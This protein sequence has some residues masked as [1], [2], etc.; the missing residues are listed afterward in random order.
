MRRMKS[1]LA[2]P[3][4]GAA[5]YSESEDV[6]WYFAAEVMDYAGVMRGTEEYMKEQCDT[7]IEQIEEREKED[8][9]LYGDEF[10]W[11]KK[12][13]SMIREA[14]E[15]IRGI[16]N[17]PSITTE[18]VEKK[19]TRAPITF[20]E[21]TQDVPEMYMIKH[22]ASSGQSFPGITSVSQ[23]Q[24]PPASDGDSRDTLSDM[25]DGRMVTN[26]SVNEASGGTSNPNIRNRVIP[27]VQYHPEPPQT[28]G[29]YTNVTLLI[30]STKLYYNITCPL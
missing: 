13:A 3:R 5:A 7:E 19:Q 25:S 28:T 20:N 17:A 27:H 1:T 8:D 21:P 24:T 4:D 10:E 14:Q 16:G 22:A 15:R 12:A 11:L 18:P 6:P 23:A 9:L 30:T 29:I 2:L 26:T